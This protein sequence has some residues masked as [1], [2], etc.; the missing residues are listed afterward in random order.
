MPSIGAA[1]I[2][3]GVE[4]RLTLG[5]LVAAGSSWCFRAAHPGPFGFRTSYAPFR[6]SR[7]VSRPA[8][9]GC[10]MWSESSVN[11]FH[12][13]L[14][15][16]YLAAVP[17]VVRTIRHRFAVEERGPIVVAALFAGLAVGLL[18]IVMG[19]LWDGA[20]E[21]LRVGNT[22][23]SYRVERLGFREHMA[24][25]FTVAAMGVWSAVAAAYLR[26]SG[27]RADRTAG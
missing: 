3:A 12:L 22:H 27:D 5:D 2:E 4:H 25:V 9:Y 20:V 21:M 19:H 8:W 7:N 15:A 18:L 10:A 14:A 11:P 16:L 26:S 17:L 13:P 23:M 24:T 6:A 1:V